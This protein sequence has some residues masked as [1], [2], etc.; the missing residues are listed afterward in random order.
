MD[1]ASCNIVEGHTRKGLQILGSNNPVSLVHRQSLVIPNGGWVRVNLLLLLARQSQ[2]FGN[3][4]RELFH[5]GGRRSRPHHFS[6]KD[7][8]SDGNKGS[9]EGAFPSDAHRFLDDVRQWLIFL[10]SH[11]HVH[12][13]IELGR[14]FCKK[15]TLVKKK[16]E[17]EK[18]MKRPSADEVNTYFFFP[19]SQGCVGQ[20]QKAPVQGNKRL[21]Y[22]GPPDR[23]SSQQF[24]RTR[25]P[26]AYA[27][28][29]CFW[30][31]DVF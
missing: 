30:V 22:V 7:N 19:Q 23:P 18:K 6:N 4:S 8:R 24:A 10:R 15:E 26:S 20:M 2:P 14:H 21:E 28:Y 1:V 5:R 31:L 11:L 16:R 17:E 27:L 3:R 12:I 9:R 29:T 25:L 13:L